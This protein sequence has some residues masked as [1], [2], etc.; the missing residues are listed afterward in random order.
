MMETQEG[1]WVAT[2][3]GAAGAV[4]K[5]V[6]GAAARLRPTAKPLH[7][8]GQLVSGT[9]HRTGRQPESGVAW[10]DQPGTD[11]VQVRLSRA[12]GLPTGWPDIFGLA[13]R[14]P[15][16]QD[17]YGDV[18]LASTGRKALSRFVLLPGR[19]PTETTYSCLIPYRSAK[20]PLLLAAHAT[21]DRTLDL[22]YA[23]LLGGWRSFG[24]LVLA[25][26]PAGDLGDA[27]DVGPSFDPVLNQIPGLDYYPWAARL[28]EGAYRAARGSR[29]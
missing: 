2:A 3:S 22:A 25:S 4:L 1:R 9:I 28:R 21:G 8:R 16:G 7:P 13:V 12:I 10:I 6:F 24:Q 5:G 19:E 29:T 17:G 26:G 27:D 23:G 14:I 11:E 18:L 15:T 20:G